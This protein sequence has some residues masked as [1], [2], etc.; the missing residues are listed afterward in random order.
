MERMDM[1]SR[2]E[3]LKVLRE[4]YLEAITRKEKS[5]ILDEYCANT[6]QVRKYVIR[7]IQPGVDLKPKQRKK[8]KEIYDGQVRAALARIWEIFDYPCGQRLKPLFE[9]ELDRL[10]RLGELKASDEVTEKL[11]RISSATIDR[12]LKHQ[13]GLLH[14]SRSR[15]RPKPGSLL[16]QKIPIRLTE[17][18]TSQLGYVE[19]DMVVHCG[20]ST[21]GEY[22]NTLST[23]EISSGWWEGEAIMGK[24]QEHSFWALKQIRKRT[25]FAWRGLDSDN[26]SEFINQILYKY[27]HKERIEFTRSR[28]NRKNDNAYIEQKNWTHVRKVLGYLRYDTIEELMIINALYHHE[29]RLYK[30]FFQPVMKLTEKVRIGGSVKRKY[31]IPKTPYQRLMGSEQ[32]SEEAREELERIYLSLNPAE[33]KREI[34]AKLEELYKI[35]EEKR[36]TQQIDPYKKLVPRLVTSYMMQ[37]H[38]VGSPT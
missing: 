33:L 21:L 6:G 35:Y 13:R 3:Y 23:T 36:K 16:K 25:P 20:S 19:A 1:H 15:A 8:R 12:K 22:V 34:D 31:D 14:L 5:R 24:S 27:C 29:L 30:N 11:N 7:K 28:P 26:G 2:N 9:L 32:I 4:R 18:D 10:R 38:P 17:W 37:Q